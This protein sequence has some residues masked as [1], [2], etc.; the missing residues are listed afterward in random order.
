MRL[1]VSEF[2]TIHFRNIWTDLVEK[3]KIEF[4]HWNYLETS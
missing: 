3:T 4:I 2:V 1:F